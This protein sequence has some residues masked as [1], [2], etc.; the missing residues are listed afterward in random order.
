MFELRRAPHHREGSRG[1][2]GRSISARIGPKGPQSTC[3]GRPPAFVR[4]NR[5]SGRTSGPSRADR[6]RPQS[7]KRQVVRKRDQTGPYDGMRLTKVGRRSSQA[8]LV[9]SGPMLA[10]IHQPSAPH[11]PRSLAMVQGATRHFEQIPA[12]GG[13]PLRLSPPLG[14]SPAGAHTRDAIHTVI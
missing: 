3:Y 11:D 13:N 7:R 2:L 10:E 9:L 6:V 4:R 5:P 1:A 12:K 14:F 8:H